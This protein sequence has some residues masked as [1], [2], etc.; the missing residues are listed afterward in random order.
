[1]FAFKDNPYLQFESEDGA[2]KPSDSDYLIPVV[3]KKSS[4]DDDDDDDYISP[5]VTT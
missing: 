3:K 2:A 1:M 4:F 5:V